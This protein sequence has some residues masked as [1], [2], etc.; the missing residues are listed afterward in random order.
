MPCW[1]CPNLT[2]STGNYVRISESTPQSDDAVTGSLVDITSTELSIA[3]DDRFP[4]NRSAD[5]ANHDLP[6]FR[7][8]LWSSDIATQRM[9]EA[10]RC[11][12]Y[13]VGD[14]IAEDVGAETETILSGTSL[15][16]VLLKAQEVEVVATNSTEQPEKPQAPN[17]DSKLAL[18]DD[19]FES[20]GS[21]S[22]DS[23]VQTWAVRHRRS[24]GMNMEGD[25]IIQNMNQSQIKAMALM[26]S[27][28]ISLIQGVRSIC[29]RMA[30]QLTPKSHSP[31]ERARRGQLPKRS[32]F[33]KCTLPYRNLSLSVRTPMW[34]LIISWRLSLRPG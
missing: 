17:L 28:R 32:D 16:D 1:L 22:A 9:L 18:P 8:D 20:P 2:V 25:P 24:P 31:L 15:K 21:F 6:I 4:L 26:I 33:S 29:H 13:N 12:K 11:L 23:R 3:F 10:M 5:S 14:Q 27:N 34:P 7:I 19:F 30:A